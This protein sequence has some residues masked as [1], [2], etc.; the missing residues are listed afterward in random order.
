[1]TAQAHRVA[2][3]INNDYD[4][5]LVV[6]APMG[7]TQKAAAKVVK[8]ILSNHMESLGADALDNGAAEIANGALPRLEAAGFHWIDFRSVSISDGGK[9]TI[10]S[11]D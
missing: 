2:I 11:R 1:M 10:E 7:M 8:G 3:N 6:L 9:I 5:L 4:N